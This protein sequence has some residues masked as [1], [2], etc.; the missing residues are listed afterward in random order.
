VGSS[1]PARS[2]GP[3]CIRAE[4]PATRSR[5]GCLKND[6]VA[7]PGA[8]WGPSRSSFAGIR[9]PR[10]RG[11]VGVKWLED[12]V[13][14]YTDGRHGT[15]VPRPDFP[16]ND[17]VRGSSPRVGSAKKSCWGDPA[18]SSAG[19]VIRENLPECP[20]AEPFGTPGTPPA[21]E[22][23]PPRPNRVHRHARARQ[24]DRG[25]ALSPGHR[26]RFTKAAMPP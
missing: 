26:G 23:H 16:R 10:V 25:Q 20:S 22:N 13:L 7:A 9:V 5:I 12:W 24:R 19:E 14:G 3:D 8:F 2:S 6:S 21:N 15:C 17:G 4:A 1:S 11:H 18:I